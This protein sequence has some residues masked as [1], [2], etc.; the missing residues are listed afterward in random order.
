MNTDVSCV[1]SMMD[2]CVSM[3]TLLKEKKEKDLNPFL[4]ELEGK[5]IVQMFET[6][7]T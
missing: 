3:C 6:F 1:V 2:V 4:S 7:L 5:K